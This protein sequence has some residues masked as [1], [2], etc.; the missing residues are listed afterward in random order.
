[1]MQFIINLFHQNSK[2]WLQ[3]N[4]FVIRTRLL[5]E[6]MILEVRYRPSAFWLVIQR[7]LEDL[8]Q[9]IVFDHFDEDVFAALIDQFAQVFESV[10]H[11]HV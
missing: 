2:V 11:L 4:G 3:L 9:L 1:M 10:R 8:P 6:L 5:E 7:D